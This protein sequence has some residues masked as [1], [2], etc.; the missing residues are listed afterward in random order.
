[1]NGVIKATV[2]GLCLGTGLTALVGCYEYR[3]LVQPM[4]AGKV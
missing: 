3:Q 4:L 1:M 2:A